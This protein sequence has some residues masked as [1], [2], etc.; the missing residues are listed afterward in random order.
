M[1]VNTHLVSML[2]PLNVVFNLEGRGQFYLKSSQEPPCNFPQWWSWLTL[3][4]EVILSHILT[5]L[6]FHHYCNSYLIINEQVS[7][8][9]VTL[10]IAHIFF[11][12][13]SLKWKIKER[14]LILPLRDDLWYDSLFASIYSSF[15]WTIDKGSRRERK[16]EGKRDKSYVM[17]SIFKCMLLS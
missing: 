7:P 12:K 15:L 3:N 1:I 17:V 8:C 4:S 6:I 10:L 5:R 14:N 2:Y 16:R 11:R 9:K 13:K